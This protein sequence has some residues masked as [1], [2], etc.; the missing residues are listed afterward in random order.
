MK[1]WK[2]GLFLV[3]FFVQTNGFAQ[4]RGA[5]KLDG[6]MAGSS[7]LETRFPYVVLPFVFQHYLAEG[8]SFP[9]F[10]Y[11]AFSRHSAAEQ[12]Y[13]W[14]LDASWYWQKNRASKFW[15]RPVFKRGSCITKA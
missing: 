2:A 11:N 3:A 5:I 6:I 9:L 15:R 8:A 10:R 7:W 1:Q 12:D 14:Q 4:S 13:L